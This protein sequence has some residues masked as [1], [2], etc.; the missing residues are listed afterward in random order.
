MEEKKRV[1]QLTRGMMSLDISISK[2]RI[3]DKIGQ[4]GTAFSL[5]YAI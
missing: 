4:F 1:A 5:E 2:V 3:Q